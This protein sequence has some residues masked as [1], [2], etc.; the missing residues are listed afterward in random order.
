MTEKL[1]VARP[2][3]FETQLLA[4]GDNSFNFSMQYKNLLS[5]CSGLVVSGYSK[6]QTEKS[7]ETKLDKVRDRYKKL[8]MMYVV[9]ASGEFRGTF[10]SLHLHLIILCF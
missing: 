7:L 3:Q 1:T 2:S 8:K 9:D 6:T 5:P 10:K 4:Y